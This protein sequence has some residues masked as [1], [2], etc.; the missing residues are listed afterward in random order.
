MVLLSRFHK[1]CRVAYLRVGLLAIALSALFIPSLK[2]VKSVGN[3]IFTI[4]VNGNIIGKVED[5]DTADRLISEA[6]RQIVGDNEDIVLIEADCK[7]VGAEVLVA[8]TDEED[9]MIAKLAKEFKSSVK[10]T[11]QHAYTVKIDD[12]MVNLSS[13]GQVTQLLDASI[14]R[15][16]GEGTFYTALAN[17]GSR[18]LPVFIPKIYKN[19][20]TGEEENHKAADY[21]DGDG[22]F[23][24]FDE[25]FKDVKAS[26]EQGFD[27]FDYGITNVS[28]AN[29]VEVVESYLPSSQVTGIED[30]IDEVT[31]DKEE[32]TIYE[33]KPGDTLSAISGKTGISVDDIIAMNESITSA[34]S[35]IRVGDEITVTIPQPELSV[36]REELVYYEGTYEAETIYKYNDEW[37]TTTE[38]TLQDPSS[39]YHKA[40]QKLTYL[41]NDVVSTE[42]VKEEIVAEAIPRIVEKGTK[43]PPTYIKPISGGRMT[44]GFGSRTATIRGMTSYHGAIDWAT[45]VGTAVMASCGGTVTHAGW[46]SS[47]G[48]C[49]FIKHPDGKETRYAHLSKVLVSKGDYVSQGQK[50]ALSGN[51]GVSTGPH[52][53]FEMRINGKA[54]NPLNYLSY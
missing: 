37:Y 16:A 41:N 22:I 43:I 15:Y 47:Y 32:K 42:V 44:S 14:S 31:K 26:D 53:H 38:V 9:V 21:L 49:I 25:I 11:M 46:M 40:V 10:E 33:V 48:Y 5:E 20:S 19:T 7:V 13:A 23:Q 29:S 35:T 30:A 54:V 2:M 28:F 6:R 17:D 34:N 45:P 51:T 27:S 3:N 39:G 1:K 36:N 18:E 8:A 12:Y 50:I 52:I 4:Y 24:Q